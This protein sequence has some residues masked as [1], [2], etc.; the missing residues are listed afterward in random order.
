MSIIIGGLFTVHCQMQKILV[1]K[2]LA[3]QSFHSFDEENVDAY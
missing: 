3:N 1:G 2:T